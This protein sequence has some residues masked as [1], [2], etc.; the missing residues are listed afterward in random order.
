MLCEV[1]TV[2]SG[3]YL[4]GNNIHVSTRDQR[5]CNFGVFE[6]KIDLTKIDDCLSDAVRKRSALVADGP[7]FANLPLLVAFFFDFFADFL[8]F[9]PRTMDKRFQDISGILTIAKDVA[10][11]KAFEKLSVKE[12]E[13]RI[14]T[15]LAA[16][17]PP[18]SK[19]F[20]LVRNKSAR[21]RLPRDFQLRCHTERYDESN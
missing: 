11:T 7:S 4:R 13:L 15:G 17:L 6:N 3:G 8:P 19:D 5:L 10:R 16:G 2:F 14:R 1:K 21:R 18:N 9:Y 12:Q 20:V